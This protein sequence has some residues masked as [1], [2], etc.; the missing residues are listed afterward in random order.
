MWEMN[1]VKIYRSFRDTIR[2]LPPKEQLKAW[3]AIIDYGL[4]GT[5]PENLDPLTDIVFTSV[6]PNIDA[7]IKQVTGGKKGGSK[8]PSKVPSKGSRRGVLR[9]LPSEVEEEVEVED[10]IYKA[11]RRV[12]KNK[13]NNFPQRNTDLNEL[14]NR[15][16]RGS[17]NA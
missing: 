10:D 3:N 6:K 4:D 2:K 9:Y 11:P 8:V 5:E 15:V 7:Y 12:K 13:F 17:A 14:E 16:L 1:T